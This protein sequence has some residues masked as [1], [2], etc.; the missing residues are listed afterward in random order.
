M[1]DSMVRIS[2]RR[3]LQLMGVSG[4][5][6]AGFASVLPETVW[7]Q[8]R[9][10]TL[11]LG[12]DISDIV[13]LDPARIATYT[14]PMMVAAA[15]DTLCTMKPGE[16]INLAPRLATKWE[17][18]SGGTQFRFWLRDGVKFASGNPVTAEDWK[19]SFDRL[20]NLKDQPSGYISHVDRVEIAE[21]GKAL[22]IFIK[23]A[24]FP[25]LT[26]LC[27]PEFVVVEKSQIEK[28]GGMATPAAA[29][30]DKAREWLDKNSAGTGAYVITGWE[31]NAQIQFTRNEH[32][33]GEKPAFARVIVRHINDGAAQLLALRRNN[34]DA[35]FNLIP[36]QVKEV[37]ADPTIRVD[38]LVSA[39]FCYMAL[40]EEAAINPALAKK[41]CR[42][43]IGYAIDYDGIINSL[44]GGEALRPA[45]FL[46]IGVRGS[47]KEIAQEV[48]FKL[49]PDKAKELLKAAGHPDGFEFELAFSNAAFNGVP[50]QTLALKIQA[51][52]A[53]VGIK[54]N[55]RPQDQLNMRND[56]LKGLFRGGLLTY[57]NPPAVENLG[58]ADAVV[59]RVAKR[60]RWN[61]PEET[62]KW[63]YDIAKMTD[64]DAQA[65][66]WVEWQK[67]MV[68]QA[69]LIVLFQP[70]YQIG[71]SNNVGEFPLTAAGWIVDLDGAKPKT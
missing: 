32:Y 57:W 54:A 43:A 20:I 17:T 9:K 46:P 10:D 59:M 18:L 27:A 36:E 50:Y 5:G 3:A 40:M 1:T 63:T 7:A 61:V 44:I 28:V 37:K 30:E 45:H 47:T 6:A 8:T 19:F 31:R 56:Y 48:G 25:T 65:K 60:L 33:W 67:K 71:V 14:G 49:D 42:Q 41:E 29:K 4:A 23:E 2:R 52:L 55:L 66:A 16:Y 21:G 68:D 39:D 64:G 70:I 53:K 69:N 58:W 24:N 13:T 11:V 62:R 35:A 51:D 22:D 15:Y 38:P 12:L 26:T 34:I